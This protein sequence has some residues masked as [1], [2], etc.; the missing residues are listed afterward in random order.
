MSKLTKEDLHFFLL[1]LHSLTGIVPIGIFLAF[2]LGVNSLRTVGVRQYQFSIDLINNA[3][4]LF[5]IEILFIYVPLLFHSAIGFYITFAGRINV[6]RYPYYRNWM[7]TLQRITGAV[8]F[9]FLVYHMGTTVV[10]KVYYGKGLFDAAPFLIDVMNREFQTWGGRILYL[11][12][13]FS[14]A[15]HFAN[16]LWGFC[17]SWGVI[18]GPS[19]QRNAG[20]VFILFGLVLGLLGAVTVIEFSLHPV[21]VA[22]SFTG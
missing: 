17:V 22:P 8:V 9:A 6:R 12:G 10:P 11:V 7:Y 5:G 16:G 19:A 15:F 2:H 21:P 18:V 3:P 1:K 20:A 13:I 14:A 4:F